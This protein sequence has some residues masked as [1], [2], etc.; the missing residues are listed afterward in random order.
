LRKRLRPTARDLLLELYRLHANPPAYAL[1]SR[2]PARSRQPASFYPAPV[3]SCP[4]PTPPAA[5]EKQV[6]IAGCTLPATLPSPSRGPLPTP[7]SRRRTRDRYCNSLVLPAACVNVCDQPLA[8]F[9]L[10]STAFIPTRQPTCCLL[11]YLL[12]F[13][14]T[15][16]PGR[17]C[18]RAATRSRQPASFYL[19]PVASCPLPTPPAAYEKQVLIAGC[20]LP[21]T[22]PWP[23]RGPLPTPCSR[24]RT[25]D[26]YCNSL[27]LPAACV[28]VCDQPLATFF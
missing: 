3:A 21:A 19:A 18:Q 10:S 11:A 1:P 15:R 14:G 26:R 8:T 4:L 25:R 22:L 20:T 17:R 27:V 13:S 24:R 9:F 2:L 5:Y 12:A 23:S 28:N 6:L 16:L 7:C